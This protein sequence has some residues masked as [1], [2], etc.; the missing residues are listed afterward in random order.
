MDIDFRK[1]FFT[2][3]VF[4]GAWWYVSNHYD[5]QDAFKWAKTRPVAA[6]RE[7]YVYYVGMIYYA[8][9]K[10]TEAADVFRELLT[11]EATGH[12]EAKGMM[13]MGRCLQDLRRFEEARGAYER[14]IEFFPT[15]PDIEIV[16]NNYEFIKFR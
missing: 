10:S 3:A 11:E 6:D 2:I 5:L 15:G 8:K 1:I 16:K 9:D 4:A 13:R 12:Y 7:K 14:Y